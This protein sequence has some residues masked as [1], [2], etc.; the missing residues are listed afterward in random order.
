MAGL[1][2][3][4][5]GAGS[6]GRAGGFS[7]WLVGPAARRRKLA[8]SL[9]RTFEQWGYGF[10]ATPLVEPLATVAAGVGHDAELQL[11]RFMDADGDMLAL[12]AERTVSVARVVAT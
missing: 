8:E 10:I 1:D 5:L 6:R 2:A 9:V 12:V 7:D 4:T 3:P 11:F